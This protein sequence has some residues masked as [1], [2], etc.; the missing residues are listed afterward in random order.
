MREYKLARDFYFRHFINQSPVKQEDAFWKYRFYI[1]NKQDLN[2]EY[3][4]NLFKSIKKF[5]KK[6]LEDF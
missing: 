1:L 6:N 4:R 5:R 2:E 3:N